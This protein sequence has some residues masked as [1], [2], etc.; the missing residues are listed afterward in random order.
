MGL[1]YERFRKKEEEEAGTWEEKKKGEKKTLKKEKKG[2]E[3]EEKENTVLKELYVQEYNW[4][5][6]SLYHVPGSILDAFYVV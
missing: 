3:E 6:L 5:L 2:K 1:Y 4:H